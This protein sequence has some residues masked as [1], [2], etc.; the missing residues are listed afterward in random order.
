MAGAINIF[1]RPAFQGFDI[2]TAG[3]VVLFR[4]IFTGIIQADGQFYLSL[5]GLGTI[6]F[7]SFFKRG[8]TVSNLDTAI[9]R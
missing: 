3:G 2:K 5:A 9:T 4:G 6:T 1:V 8:R 7:P